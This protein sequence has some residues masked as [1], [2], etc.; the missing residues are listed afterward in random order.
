[1]LGLV[2]GRVQA[3]GPKDEALRR[4]LQPEGARSPGLKV[5]NERQGA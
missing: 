3:F 5:V 1:V 2:N 4:L